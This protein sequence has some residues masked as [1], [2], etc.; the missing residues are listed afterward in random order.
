M[1][2][3]KL[4]PADPNGHGIGTYATIVDAQQAA[5][6]LHRHLS[7]LTTSHNPLLAEIA[8]RELDVA[9]ALNTRL[10]RLASLVRAALPNEGGEGAK[11]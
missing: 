9:T 11:T 5:Y 8:L 2:E 7:I 1:T 4:P 10:S 3:P 6:A